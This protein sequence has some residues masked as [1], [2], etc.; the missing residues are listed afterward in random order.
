[1]IYW[2]ADL[3]DAEYRRRRNGEDRDCLGRVEIARVL[4]IADFRT[5]R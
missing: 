4:A 3:L 1:M 5:N 2:W